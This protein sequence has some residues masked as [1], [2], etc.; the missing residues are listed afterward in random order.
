[1]ATDKDNTDIDFIK[2]VLNGYSINPK[3]ENLSSYFTRKFKDA[4]ANNYEAE[5]FFAGCFDVIRLFVNDIERRH[6]ERKAD[7]YQMLTLTDDQS[8]KAG[9]KEE[10]ANLQKNDFEAFLPYLT[11]N[12]FYGQ[13]NATKIET[14][15][16]AMISA[17]DKA[18]QQRQKD[19]DKSEKQ[20]TTSNES[21]SDKKRTDR[22]A[23]HEYTF[24]EFMELI[25]GYN[26]IKEYTLLVNH[27]DEMCGRISDFKELLDTMSSDFVPLRKII[28]EI[29]DTNNHSYTSI[30]VYQYLKKTTNDFQEN[31][32]KI[33]LKEMEVF[34]HMELY[35]TMNYLAEIEFEKNKWEKPVRKKE[36]KLGEITITEF[37]DYREMRNKVFPFMGSLFFE[38]MSLL[39]SKINVL[40]KQKSNKSQS[41]TP[42]E[43]SQ[44]AAANSEEYTEE[45]LNKIDNAF[46]ARM[47]LSFAYNH[48]QVLQTKNKNGKPYLTKEQFLQFFKTVFI[49]G[50]TVKK[51]TINFAKG[52]KGAVQQVFYDFYSEA[53]TIPYE[54]TN[55]CQKRY[56]EL[57]CDNFTNFDFKKL[58]NNFNPNA[59]KRISS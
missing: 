53:V 27:K 20:I 58:K 45:Q 10:I 39:S 4:N 26:E 47:P 38:A 56:I 12:C 9:I 7:L 15:L 21:Q 36:V 17:K 35:E 1:M 31:E 52:E 3:E 32:M 42:P 2:L 28:N 41:E 50:N 48:F 40:E 51:L 54:I 46:C 18:L 11:N 5:D 19:A 29:E 34:K 25:S 30:E 37:T 16:N 44:P 57:A 43:Q 6:S 13:L 33:T 22:N 55:H 49:D 24:I 14:I 8:I 59:T 23:L